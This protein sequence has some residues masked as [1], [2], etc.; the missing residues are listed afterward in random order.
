[1]LE[2]DAKTLKMC[3]A[4]WEMVGPYSKFHKEPETNYCFGIG[5]C[6]T[7]VLRFEHRYHMTVTIHQ[8]NGEQLVV[9]DAIKRTPYNR[10]DYIVTK[11][12]DG[13]WSRC[14]YHERMRIRQGRRTEKDFSAAQIMAAAKV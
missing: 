11:F 3:R 1:M 2:K 5:S 6:D 8:T 4:V 10:V 14:L 12:S 9:F 13:Y 7:V